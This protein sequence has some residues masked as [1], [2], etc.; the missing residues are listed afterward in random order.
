[1]IDDSKYENEFMAESST[2]EKVVVSKKPFPHN[3]KA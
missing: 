1:L 3:A 2:T